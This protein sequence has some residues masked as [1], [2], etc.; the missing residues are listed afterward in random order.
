M[1]GEAQSST[2]CPSATH[3]TLHK[4]QRPDSEQRDFCS[5]VLSVAAVC[6]GGDNPRWVGF[7]FIYFEAC[8]FHKTCTKQEQAINLKYTYF[9]TGKTKFCTFTHDYVMKT[10][11]TLSGSSDDANS[12]ERPP[13]AQAVSCGFS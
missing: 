3:L 5:A 8:S 4:S 6:P 10:C 13:L 9:E 12:Q 2:V 11:H 7:L 1:R